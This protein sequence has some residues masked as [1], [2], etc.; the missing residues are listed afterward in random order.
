MGGAL[1]NQPQDPEAATALAVSGQA[2]A[3]NASTAIGWA[4]QRQSDAMI[5]LDLPGV[6]GIIEGLALCELGFRPIPLYNGTT[7]PSH[8]PLDCEVVPSKEIFT[9]LRPGAQIIKKSDL[10][11]D[12]PPAFLLDSRRL[13]YRGS[14]VGRYDNRWCVFPQDMP[15]ADFIKGQGIRTVIVR[16]AFIQSDLAHILRRY[17]DGGLGVF[18]CSN[19]DVQPSLFHVE[20]PSRFR[21]LAYRTSTLR[22]LKANSGGGFGGFIP[23]PEESS[24]YSG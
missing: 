21:S 11:P 13:S 6:A 5:I 3:T 20:K 16:A 18:L 19:P 2:L 23:I 15:S 10:R 17:Q 7:P 14:V 9:H 8:L 12:S 4:E 24:G 22:L 1:I